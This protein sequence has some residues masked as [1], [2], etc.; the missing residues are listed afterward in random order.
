MRKRLLAGLFFAALLLY[1]GS[2]AR[3]E[4]AKS[5][6]LTEMETGRVLYEKNAH[7]ALPM[8]STTKVMTALLA[9]EKGTLSD[10]VTASRN[11]FGV[12]GTSIYLAEGETLTLDEMLLGLMLQSGNDAA[13]AI[14]EHIAGDVDTF[15]R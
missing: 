4:S 13:V 7:Q 14:A 10:P 3:A 8:A 11:A 6:I 5:A 15:C 2:W 12:P 1:N 9:L